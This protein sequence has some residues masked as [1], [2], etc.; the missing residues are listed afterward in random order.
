M[1]PDYTKHDII[2]I[3]DAMRWDIGS[4]AINASNLVGDLT[5][6]NTG[7]TC[8]KNWYKKYLPVLKNRH[9]ISENP[10]PLWLKIT[11]QFASFTKAFGKNWLDINPTETLQNFGQTP[12]LIHLLPP[13]APFVYG[14]G[15]KLCKAA[16]GNIYRVLQDWG[17]QGNFKLLRQYYREQIDGV[18]TKL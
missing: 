12:A 7:V 15:V 8:T 4:K 16:T 6:V 14:D 3:L 5:K 1:P 9:V 13:H 18:T 2:I 17:Q 11:D 10:V